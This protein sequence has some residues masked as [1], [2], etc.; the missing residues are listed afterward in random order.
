MWKAV[1][2][3]CREMVGR[4]R[5]YVAIVIRGGGVCTKVTSFEKTENI[6]KENRQMLCSLQC[7]AVAQRAG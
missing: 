7:V 5:D 4:G 2:A 1:T 6:F 3:A